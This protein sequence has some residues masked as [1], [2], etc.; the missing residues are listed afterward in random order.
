MS[1]IPLTSA[2][3]RVC[4]LSAI[5]CF[6]NVGCA[7]YSFSFREVEA[8]LAAQNPAAAL[9]LLDQQQHADRDRLLYHLNRAMLLRMLHEYKDSNSEFE[10]AKRYIE[11]YSSKSV[12]EE[13]AAFFIND[14][15]RS[16]LGS[17]LEQVMIHLFAS[18]NYLALDNLD[19]AR[20]EA[21]QVDSRLRELAQN[22]PDSVLTMDP[23]A[24]YLS[25]IIYEDLQEW[26]DA[27]IAYRKAYQAYQEHNRLYSV[28]VPEQL[29]YD[30]LRLTQKM[31]LKDEQ[32]QLLKTFGFDEKAI[33]RG[34]AHN[35]ELILL[36][37]KDMAPVKRESSA[38][39]PN[40]KTG[41]MLRISLPY[42]EPRQSHISHAKISAANQSA[43]T[44]LVEDINR[45][46]SRT[47]ESHMGAIT[48]RAF[49]RA[50]VKHNLSRETGRD[51]GLAG[52]LINIAGI[53][54][55]RA[56]TRSW[57]T[58]PG[59]I[60]L[61]RLPLAPGDYTVTIEFVDMS[62]H[63]VKTTTLDT[64]SIRE[65]RKNYISYHWISHYSSMRH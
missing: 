38:H 33:S 53:V 23:F 1:F 28:R 4:I 64:I 8:Q 15:T 24:R 34:N 65:G 9:Q 35:S 41:Y 39:L 61:A 18:L 11:R 3:A 59:E 44:E 47:L 19:A 45:I 50:A 30:L 54:T 12:S 32:Q 43:K 17:P 16:Y 20:V 51:N 7:S 26:D 25:A 36:F 21:L 52:L 63:I 14:G 60:Q 31:G 58:L 55:E 22:D 48:A 42:Y 2:H 6:L 56:D 13:T 46:A 57:L 49:A 10:A 29:K 5:V 27:M 37:G 62:G 40:P